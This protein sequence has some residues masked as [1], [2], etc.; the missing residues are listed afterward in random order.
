MN[1]IV[2]E[3]IYRPKLRS[4]P[5]QN[6][7]VSSYFSNSKILVDFNRIIK[8]C[9]HKIQTK[10]PSTEQILSYSIN[11]YIKAINI[12]FDHSQDM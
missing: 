8:K 12:L 1:H 6:H 9:W 10:R 3:M 7:E 5:P 11:L 4:T 2:N